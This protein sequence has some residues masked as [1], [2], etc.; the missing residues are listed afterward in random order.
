[1]TYILYLI[2][3]FAFIVSLIAAVY[4]FRKYNKIRNRLPDI[5]GEEELMKPY[6]LLM[7]ELEQK[8]QQLKQQSL[9]HHLLVKAIKLKLWK[10]DLKRKEIIWEGNLEKGEQGTVVVDVDEHL[11][12][13]LP[14]YRK[15]IYEAIAGLEKGCSKLIDE[16]FLYQNVDNTLSWRNIYG[17]IY[18][19]D[20][21]GKPAILIGGT[22]II[23]ERKKLESDLRKAKDKAEEANRLKTAFL[24]NMSHEIRTPLN[25][26]VGFSS[27]LADTE[28]IAEKKEFCNLINHNNALLLKIVDDI[29][30][31]SKIEAGYIDLHPTWFCLSDLIMESATE[32]RM[33]AAGRLDIR[34]HKPG[35]GYMVELDTKRVKQILNNFLSNA[36][37]HTQEG[38]IDITYGVTEQ[39]IEIKV[40]DTGCGIPQDKLPVI[41]ERFEKVDSFTQGV[42]LGLPICKSIAECMGGSIGLT[43]EVGV[44]TTVWVTLPCST[45]PTPKL[46]KEKLIDNFYS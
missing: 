40:T 36:L 34:I 4:Y 7:Q 6:N 5:D 46:Y 42:G 2:T 27:I 20:E 22:Q 29:L 11:S 10:W 1:M 44:G 15:R 3:L 28:D 35:Q 30:D 24:A 31:I 8:Q 43:S 41:F 25:A 32:Y 17:I 12:H 19:Y 9:Q 21:G 14:E 38:Y 33:K 18:E 45:A 37:K 26:I 39:G 16:E 23:D 13:V